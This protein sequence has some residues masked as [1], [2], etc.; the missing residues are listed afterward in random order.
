MK[1]R[2]LSDVSEILSQ[3]DGE[4]EVEVSSCHPGPKP[5]SPA[6][7]SASGPSS[8]RSEHAKQAAGD[9]SSESEPAAVAPVVKK[10]SAAPG[11]ARPAAVALPRHA[12]SDS[13]FTPPGSPGGFHKELS[14]QELYQSARA[15]F[16]GELQPQ[17][18]DLV[19]LEHPVRRG[20]T[21]MVTE[22]EWS[23]T[24]GKAV[25]AVAAVA[26][27]EEEE[28]EE[29][30]RPPSPQPS[31]PRVRSAISKLPSC[32]KEEEEEEVEDE[33]EEVCRLRWERVTPCT[34][35]MG[36]CSQYHATNA[37]TSPC[38]LSKK[39]SLS[40]EKL[41]RGTHFSRSLPGLPLVV[42]GL[43]MFVQ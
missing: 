33:E 2:P 27:E 11:R 43:R 6:R 8:C 21:R 36:V 35:V 42:L 32:F 9:S 39:L 14:V 13:I 26:E 31:P 37:R 12:S 29:P 16:G 5:R 28:E 40:P 19:A 15:S 7:M 4:Y 10:E 20:P 1:R 3:Y 22:Q 41:R 18:G 30:W 17:K 25:P 38:L 34:P 24:E 23:A